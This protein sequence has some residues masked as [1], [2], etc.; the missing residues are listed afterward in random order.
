MGS[1]RQTS[2]V[3]NAF[4]P[5]ASFTINVCDRSFLLSWKSLISDGPCNFFTRHFIKNR[6][7]SR[8]L[9][10]DRNL[11]TFILI[12]RHLRGYPVVAKDY[13]QHQDL[14]SD[15]HYF[16]LEKLTQLLSQFVYL[17]VGGT[18][19]RLRWDLF[20][21]DGPRNYFTVFLKQSVFSPH[22]AL[23][24][25]PPIYIERD[26]N[27]F[28]DIIRHLQGYSISIRDEQHRKQLL[29]D[30]QFYLL[31]KLSDKLKSS[32]STQDLLLH[33]QDVR[34]QCF[35]V[36]DTILYRQGQE[37][38]SLSI[39][40]N[41]THADL[42]FAHDISNPVFELEYDIPLSKDSQWTISKQIQIST[43]CAIIIQQP[44][45]EL[46]RSEPLPEFSLFNTRQFMFL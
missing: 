12:A 2:Q 34:P 10:I 39:Q 24:E 40:F 3:S 33:Y 29:S 38:F 41:D 20:D 36:E 19:F 7:V 23:G 45:R 4:D 43:D 18:S 16:G 15:A 35:L 27:V 28:K 42:Y 11:D 32:L 21:R 5:N 13:C 37:T 1:V 31:R 8:V 44:G 26:P 14:L 22:T 17:N 30:A 46:T 9:H 6:D 25:S